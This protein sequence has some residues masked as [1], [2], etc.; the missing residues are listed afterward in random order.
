MSF[1][2]KSPDIQELDD[3]A[4]RQYINSRSACTAVNAKGFEVDIIRRERPKGP[5][6]YDIPGRIHR[7]QALA[8]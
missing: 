8:I 2:P 1:I 7:V 5:D 4:K 6:E 3:H